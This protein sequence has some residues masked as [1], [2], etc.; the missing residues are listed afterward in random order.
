MLIKP[1]TDIGIPAPHKGRSAQLASW[2]PALVSTGRA[3]PDFCKHF[4]RPWMIIQS[5]HVCPIQNGPRTLH[6]S[7]TS[8][9]RPVVK[10]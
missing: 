9:R 2:M 6:L 10:Q 8:R 4:T 7:R 3:D 1:Y 5:F